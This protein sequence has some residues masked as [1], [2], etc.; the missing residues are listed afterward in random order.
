MGGIKN[1]N[2][3]TNLGS[4]SK[5]KI[6]HHHVKSNKKEKQESNHHE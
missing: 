6:D 3:R 1:I 5:A 4:N 2:K